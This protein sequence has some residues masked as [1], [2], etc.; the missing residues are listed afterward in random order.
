MRYKEEITD[1]LEDALNDLV[2]LDKTLSKGAITAEDV[3]QRIRN[4]KRFVKLVKER[5]D[6]N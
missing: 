2:M 6:Q 3:L 5:V 4:I 1:A